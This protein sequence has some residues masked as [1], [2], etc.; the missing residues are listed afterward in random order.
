MKVVDIKN[1]LDKTTNPT[2]LFSSQN[3]SFPHE[4]LKFLGINSRNINWELIWEFAQDSIYE[5]NNQ[6]NSSSPLIS[7]ELKLTQDSIIGF[8]THYDCATKNLHF[9]K[10]N[11][12]K[13]IP[14]GFIKESSIHGFGLFASQKIRQGEQLAI[15]DGQTIPYAKYLELSNYFTNT[16]A[17][18]GLENYFFMEWNML[19]DELVLSRAYRTQYSYINHSKFNANVKVVKLK[20]ENLCALVCTKEIR[21][22]EEILIDYT[23]EPLPLSYLASEE[24]S[25][26]NN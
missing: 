1:I 22:T 14:K 16:E 2:I 15:L 23:K 11:V 24:K 12:I 18:N 10:N 25:F 5:L 8:S 19:E 3:I 7:Y 6:L 13:N 4:A 20:N 9:V 26:L 17:I 21:P